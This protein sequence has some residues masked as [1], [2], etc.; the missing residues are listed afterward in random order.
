MTTFLKTIKKTSLVIIFTLMFLSSAFA[1]EV[2]NDPLSE[3][4]SMYKYGALENTTSSPD[5][6]NNI[7]IPEEVLSMNTVLPDKATISANKLEDVTLKQNFTTEQ[8]D[9][10]INTLEKRSG[11]RI[12]V[13][14]NDLGVLKFQIVQIRDQILELNTLALDKEGYINKVQL[15]DQLKSLKEEQIKVRDFILS[16]ENQFSLFGWLIAS[17]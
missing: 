16:R 15:D 6:V 17:L 3:Y 14:G 5:L 4:S 13:I 12:F 7:N 11:L 10:A 8:I 1:S 9:K 2:N